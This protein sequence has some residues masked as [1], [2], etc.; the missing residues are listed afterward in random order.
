[1][2]RVLVVMGLLATGAGCSVLDDDSGDVP[3][4]L[5]AATLEL[6]GPN[7]DIG[8]AHQRAL[9]LQA[10]RIN[11][12]GILGGRR[13]RV[14]TVDNQSNAGTAAS[15]I[16]DFAGDQAVTAIVSGACAQCAIDGTKVAND[17][18]VPLISLAAA[19][20]IALPAGDQRHLPVV[21][22]LGAV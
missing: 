14:V 6:T 18:Q 17:R 1:A 10:E 5:V 21:G 22:G 16:A 8:I 12:N 19:S 11:Q 15:Q 4:L 20:G 13:I 2:M 9:N 3:D 7:A